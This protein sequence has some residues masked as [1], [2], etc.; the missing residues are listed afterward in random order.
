MMLK[1]NPSNHNDILTSSNPNFNPA[2]LENMAANPAI[3]SQ[4]NLVTMNMLSMQKLKMMTPGA[5][6]HPKF[7]FTEESTTQ[8]DG[9]KMANFSGYQNAQ[10]ASS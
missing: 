1:K 7:Q 10:Q 9:I 5:Q 8:N 2:Q 3:A 6:S 4:Q